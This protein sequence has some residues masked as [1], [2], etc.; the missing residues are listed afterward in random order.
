MAIFKPL[1]TIGV[2]VK[3]SEATL[4]EALESIMEQDF[5]H[6]L[7]E[8]IFVDDGSTDSTLSII[9]RYAKRLDMRVTI[10]SQDWK[11]LGFSRNTIVNAAKGCYIAWVDG[12]MILPNDHV[13]KQVEFMDSNPDVGIAKAKYG[14]LESENLIGFLEN[15]AFVAVDSLFGGKSTSRVLGTGGSIYR[16]KAIQE[17]NGFDVSISG[18]GE[19][20]DAEHRIKKAG[21]TLH[22]GSPASFYEKRRNTL[23]S[24]WREAFWHGYGGHVLFRKNRRA[25]TLLKMTPFAGFFAGAWYATVAYRMT[26][27]RIVFLL[28]LQYTFKRIAWCLGFLKGQ[29]DMNGVKR[30]KSA[31]WT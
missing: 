15:I 1:V 18:V 19:D 2:C 20:M 11:G 14:I 10:F 4:P 13:T 21:W 9:E 22:L 12:D 28:P 5:P 17:V 6:E 25:Y 8:V 3:N 24:L 27:R 29:I 31:V 7:M 23:K 26:G 30:Q 16:T